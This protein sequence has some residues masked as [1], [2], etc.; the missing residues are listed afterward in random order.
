MQL[1]V[2]CCSPQSV[3]FAARVEDKCGLSCHTYVWNRLLVWPQLQI[4]GGCSTSPLL[5]ER[6]VVDLCNNPPWSVVEA[7]YIR[8]SAHWSVLLTG[9]LQRRPCRTLLRYYYCK[10]KN[11]LVI[12]T[13][14]IS[15]KFYFRAIISPGNFTV[16]SSI[17]TTYTVVLYVTL[18]VE[19]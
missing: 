1:L 12:I 4:S 18:C 13:S 17:V 7:T 10:D 5:S 3:V 6:R 15:V 19:M 11:E 16:L 8:A 9:L 14:H 2:L